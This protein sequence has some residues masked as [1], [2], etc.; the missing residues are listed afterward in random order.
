MTEYAH[1]ETEEVVEMTEVMIDNSRIN[2]DISVWSVEDPEH[3]DEPFD[4]IILNTHTAC[5]ESD[6]P[7]TNPTTVRHSGGGMAEVGDAIA[8]YV[9]GVEFHSEIASGITY[10][11]DDALSHDAPTHVTQTAE[12]TCDTLEREP[13]GD[14]LYGETE[15]MVE[16]AHSR[17]V[18][19]G[20]NA[21][22]SA[23]T[24]PERLID[25]IRMSTYVDSVTDADLY[26]CEVVSRPRPEDPKID[27][28]KDQVDRQVRKLEEAVLD[29][30]THT[31][32]P[33]WS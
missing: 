13:P 19:T 5:N 14:D 3:S 22:V 30:G 6:I 33:E 4:E 7:R 25:I 29:N 2:V 11:L 9:A 20:I 24:E 10:T 31:T 18:E 1:E 8:D 17:I 28:I 27:L 26:G 16:Y 15:E 21:D 12:E 32:S 23:Y